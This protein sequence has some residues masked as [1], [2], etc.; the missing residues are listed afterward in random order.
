MRR[1][2]SYTRAPSR[3]KAAWSPSLQALNKP[4]I[5][6]DRG[7]AIAI[8]KK[9][10]RPWPVFPFTSA[11]SGGGET[12][13]HER[14]RSDGGEMGGGRRCRIEH[15]VGRWNECRY[16]ALGDVETSS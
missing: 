15:R 1:S 4:V 12:S 9:I 13:S 10:A 11:R 5:S 14:K 6:A 7:S 8:P 2:S 16:T 3:S